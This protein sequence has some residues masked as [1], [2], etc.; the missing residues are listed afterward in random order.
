MLRIIKITFTAI[1]M[2]AALILPMT[3]AHAEEVPVP[4]LAAPCPWDTSLSYDDA[5]CLQPKDPA[6][7]PRPEVNEPIPVPPIQPYF[8]NPIPEPPLNEGGDGVNNGDVGP[9][10]YQGPIPYEP[11]MV[12]E[13]LNDSVAELETSLQEVSGVAMFAQVLSIM[14]GIV[15]VFMI[16]AFSLMYFKL[17]DKLP[18]QY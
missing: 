12:I 15:M 18:S 3:A 10:G 9:F 13:D 16:I 6:M 7:D 5:S 17:R 11:E 8:P 14:L 4:P 2:F 1:V